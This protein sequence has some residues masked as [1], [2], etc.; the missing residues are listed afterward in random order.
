MISNPQHNYSIW[1]SDFGVIGSLEDIHTINDW[2]RYHPTQYRKWRFTG[3]AATVLIVTT[4]ETI[5][6]KEALKYASMIVS[7]SF[8]VCSFDLDRCEVTWKRIFPET[9]HY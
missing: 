1:R 2:L 8:A 9:P 5:T 7:G 6:R 3:R 4:D